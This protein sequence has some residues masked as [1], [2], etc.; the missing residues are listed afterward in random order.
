M[1][2]MADR[3]DEPDCAFCRIVS[4]ETAAHEVYR[5]DAVVG[6][7]DH[8]PLFEGHVL[9]V[10]AAHCVTLADL[11]SEDLEGYFAIVQ[12]I[13]AAL[14]LALGCTGTLV[15]MNNL[16]S[17]SVPHLHT[18]VVPRTRGDGLRGFFWPR[19]RYPDD[20]AAAAVASRISTAL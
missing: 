6:F 17:Q 11:P 18:H 1:S 12:R 14:P 9:V 16:V 2:H 15:A 13:S 19:T 20:A 7:L 3:S 4:G 10:P 5:D 8:R